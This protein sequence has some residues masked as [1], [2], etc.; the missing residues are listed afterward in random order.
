MKKA[1]AILLALAMV[2]T[3]AFAEDAATYGNNAAIAVSGNATLT[4]GMDLENDGNTGF[5]NGT[6]WKVEIPIL[7]KQ[8][9]TKAGEGSY[10][11]IQVKEAQY[12]LTDKHDNKGF[13]TGDK[14]VDSVNAKL[15]F[16]KVYVTIAGA[17][18]FSPNNVELFKPVKNDDYF[19]DDREGKLLRFEP[20]F[21]GDKFG[22]KIGYKDEKYD[23][24]VKLA[25]KWAYDNDKYYQDADE[26]G[27][28]DGTF[29]VLG[30]EKSKYAVG[31]DATVKPMD[32]LEVAGTFNYATWKRTTTTDKDLADGVMTVGAKAV[33]KPMEGLEITAALD[34]TND[35]V[36][37][38]K[39]GKLSDIFAMEGSVSAK[40]KF[41][42]AGLY[43]ASAAT[44]YTTKDL[45]TDDKKCKKAPT[46]PALPEDGDYDADGDTD[47]DDTTAFDEATTTYATD[48]AAWAAAQ[49]WFGAYNKDG[50]NIAD[51]AAYVKLT[52]GDFV[53][54][55][56]GWFTF[57][58][59][60]PSTAWAE[61]RDGA[62]KKVGA[63][64]P[65]MIGLGAN[66]K[67]AMNDVNYVKPFFELYGQNNIAVYKDS[68]SNKADSVAMFYTVDDKG[69]TVKG[70]FQN[71]LSLG[72][73]YGLFSNAVVT[74]KFQ[75]GDTVAD[76]GIR[77]LKDTMATDKGDFTLA[78][79]VTY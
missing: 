2:A 1:L 57:M 47:A 66:Y 76:H 16:G 46:A 41:I 10:A 45:S 9:F 79:K 49:S 14:K 72:V 43:Y 8:S 77:M 65:I 58:M 31:F 64:A 35:A 24:G 26:D 54:N 11:E 4:W 74:A 70:G 36:V 15:V 71:T 25:S 53:E 38:D 51:I 20:D 17:P 55:L 75:A 42:E 63:S 61:I 6:E 27:K 39:K 44:P 29:N 40:Y 32:M 50:V 28:T 33:A 59:Y 23:V 56:D 3:A 67:Y 18:D 7:A 22:T 21:T 37:A 78:C 5:K 34:G 60:N 30:T 12:Y 13:A 62:G 68:D 52:D 48:A 19:A 69:K 73:D